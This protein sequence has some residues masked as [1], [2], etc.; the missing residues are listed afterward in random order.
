[1]AEHREFSSGGILV[2]VHVFQNSVEDSDGDILTVFVS[3]RTKRKFL[4]TGRVGVIKEILGS[5]LDWAPKCAD[6]GFRWFTKGS[7]HEYCKAKP[8]TATFF[9]LITHY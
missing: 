2:P 9:F 6:W 7:S 3:T 5:Y 4:Q 1:V 8:M